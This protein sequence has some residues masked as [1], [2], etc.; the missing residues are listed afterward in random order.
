MEALKELV[1][2]HRFTINKM[3]TNINDDIGYFGPKKKPF[4]IK[5]VY[6]N[7]VK[8]GRMLE[9]VQEMLPDAGIT[10]LCLNKNV[11]CSPHKDKKKRAVICYFFGQFEGGALVL[12]ESKKRY[13]EKEVWH[14]P[15][16]GSEVT[17]YNEPIISGTKYSVVAYSRNG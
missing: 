10:E 13:E 9:I 8:K 12:E 4:L 15:F 14:G 16:L 6:S 5:G 1:F 11:V 2:N 3:R 7:T 17:H